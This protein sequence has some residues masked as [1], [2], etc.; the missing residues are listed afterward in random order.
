MKEKVLAEKRKKN[1]K[2]YPIYEMLGKDF[3]FYYGI[4]VL[5][6][7]QV[8]GIS[9]ANI[10]LA[11]SLY[12][13]FGIF[14]QVPI[15][16]FIK[17]VGKHRALI[18]GNIINTI[19]MG[20]ILV[21]PNFIIYIMEEFLNAIAFGIK[22]ITETSVLEDSIPD[23][24]KKG[25]IFTHIHSKGYSR[26]CYISAISMVLS[27]IL[28]DT[29]P[30]IP[31]FIALMFCAIT[32]VLSI[33]F[34]EI[35]L[36]E[37]KEE[38]TL[39]SNFKEVFEGFKFIFK[40]SRLKSLL[41]SVGFLW[42]IFCLFGTY[43]ITILKELNFSATLIGIIT[44]SY[45]I[46]TGTMSRKAN[47]FNKTLKNKTLSTLMFSSTISFILIGILLLS[48]SNNAIVLYIILML[49][50]VTATSKGISQVIKSRYLGNFA[51]DN[52]VTL[53]YSANNIVENLSRMIIG[54]IGSLILSHFDI[55][56]TMLII[57]V[58]FTVVAF[59]LYQYM[60]TRLGLKPEEYDKKDI[61]FSID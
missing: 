16:M 23:S 5:F 3:L 48:Y 61:E 33:N 25:E 53:I 57:G 37:S 39:S 42:G 9:D 12:A 21:C 44:A 46:V 28:Y 10:V 45:Y 11:S 20:I 18:A 60:Q 43:R 47:F 22:H 40:S 51:N 49:Y 50:M 52:I 2:L 56:Y 17:K 30:Y 34:Y 32:T 31:V 19:C 24:D 14:L 26:Y 59:A 54:F 4:Q 6:L 13:F 41:L 58:L 1:M 27:G 35:D 15:S 55:R 8:K 36:A 38:Q 29:N 7:S